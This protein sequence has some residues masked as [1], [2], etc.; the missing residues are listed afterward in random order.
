MQTQTALKCPNCG[1]T[2]SKKGE[3]KNQAALNAHVNIHCPKKPTSGGNDE[4]EWGLLNPRIRE[5][6][7]ALQHGYT[8][9]CSKTGD[10]E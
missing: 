8:K 1:A 10:L 5:H 7:A 3:F 4:N 9:I 2:G 6:A